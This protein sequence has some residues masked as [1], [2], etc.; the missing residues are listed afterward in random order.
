MDDLRPKIRRALGLAVC[1]GL[2]LIASPTSVAAAAERDLVVV[3]SSTASVIR[4]DSVSGAQL[5]VSAGQNLSSPSAVVE[6]ADGS[7][8]VADRDAFAGAGGLIRVQPATGAQTVV[9]SGGLFHNPTGVVIAA[10]GGLFVSDD[11]PDGSG[12]VVRV[13]PATGA[14]S[15][16]SSG[17]LF[18]SPEGITIAPDGTL[19]VVDPKAFD[20]TGG[21][22]RVDPLTGTQLGV[23]SGGNF[24]GPRDIALAGD[25][26]VL[27]TDKKTPQP[28]GVLIAVGADGSQS[29]ISSGG[30]LNDPQGMLVQGAEV[31]I[32]D[33]GISDGAGLVRVNLSTGEQTLVSSGGLLVN[34]EGVALGAFPASGGP[35]P[36]PRLGEAVNVAPL[37]GV[38]RVAERYGGRL[39]SFK[40]LTQ[41]V[42]IGVGAAI[43][44][45]E[46]RIKLTAAG[47][48]GKLQSGVFY[49]GKFVVGQRRSDRGLT[50][51]A[52]IG[53]Y[54]RCRARRSV[55]SSASRQRRRL[56]GN[57][58]GRF[59]TRGIH[60]VA[61]VRGTKW[62]VE[63]RC[64]G[65]LTRVTRGSVTVRDF[66]RRRTVTVRHGQ[67]YLAPTR[68]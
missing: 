52:L 32:A 46:G 38:I 25:G 65:T 53:A 37:S 6:A 9:S 50:E 14:Q 61:T 21:V 39:T 55:D 29:I 49:G 11:D 45:T 4:V 51:L 59:K 5:S 40:E 42:Q 63:D 20:K 7:L 26:R 68:R 15:L 35:L 31:V 8:L 48:N 24:E 18:D 10:D 67:S 2:A 44:A 36:V 43:D 58:H 22:I 23:S 33:P 62:L 13:D 34:P 60:S 16:V 57:A 12:A 27:V 17:G 66:N 30:L 47:A 28:K 56:W 19:L 64:E 41:P 3:D 1:A 54:P